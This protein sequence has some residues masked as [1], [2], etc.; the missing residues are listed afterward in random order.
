MYS[1]ISLPVRILNI[2][3]ISNRDCDGLGVIRETIKE[4]IDLPK[5]L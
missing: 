4:T 3:S 2:L 1:Q 5:G